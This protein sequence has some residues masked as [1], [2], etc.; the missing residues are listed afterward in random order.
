MKCT[1]GVENL[2]P[3]VEQHLT[4]RARRN[5][6]G[7]GG[8]RQEW[9]VHRGK[10]CRSFEAVAIVKQRSIFGTFRPHSVSAGRTCLI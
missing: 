1:E 9:K 3:I 8:Q 4:G 7:N 10:T 2:S 5:R 6:Q